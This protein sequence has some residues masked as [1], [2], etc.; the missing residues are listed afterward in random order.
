MVKLRG[1]GDFEDLTIAGLN[2]KLGSKTMPSY[3]RSD[4]G[5][6]RR[7]YKISAVWRAAYVVLSL[8]ERAG[9]DVGRSLIFPT[10]HDFDVWDK[11]RTERVERQ[12]SLSD[13]GAEAADGPVAVDARS[14]DAS[15]PEAGGGRKR[16]ETTKTNMTP[17]Q[18]S[19]RP[20]NVEPADL[21]ELGP[22]AAA[23]AAVL[24]EAEQRVVAYRQAAVV[25]R[26]KS[27]ILDEQLRGSGRRAMRRTRS[28]DNAMRRSQSTRKT[29]RPTKAKSATSKSK[30][31][32][33]R[34]AWTTTLRPEK[35]KQLRRKPQITSSGPSE[36]RRG[37]SARKDSSFTPSPTSSLPPKLASSCRSCYKS[38]HRKSA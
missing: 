31:K 1:G 27:E 15:G 23:L 36:A 8:D 33:K 35:K 26:R 29:S 7:N 11:P 14:S 6:F 34:E 16:K 24:E 3:E 22:D 2:E 32:S 13:G 28:F 17:G 5:I 12:L 21:M 4:L 18:K 19:A 30:S 20:D 9:V 38:H 10:A 37:I 25:A